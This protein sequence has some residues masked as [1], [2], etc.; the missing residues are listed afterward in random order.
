MANIFSICASSMNLL[1]VVIRVPPA[2]GSN[3]AKR[4]ISQAK[5]DVLTGCASQ[6]A[7]EGT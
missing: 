1:S 2:I 5:V 3:E 7:R 6:I 4:L